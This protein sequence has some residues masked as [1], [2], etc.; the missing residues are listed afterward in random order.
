MTIVQTPEIIEHSSSWPFEETVD[1]L[2]RAI[3]AA[4]VT[5]FAKIDHAANARDVGIVMPPTTVLI[6][7]NAKAGTPVMLAAPLA[8]LDLPLRVLVRQREDG[9][10]AIVFHPIAAVLRRAKAPEALA[11]QLDAAQYLLLRAITT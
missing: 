6:Y 3:A 11:T 1:R 8:A 4:G 2:Q 7:G 10:T 5:I 9:T